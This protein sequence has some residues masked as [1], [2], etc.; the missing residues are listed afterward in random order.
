MSR[1]PAPD[2]EAILVSSP[3]KESQ[4]CE[5]AMPKEDKN[6]DGEM[7]TDMKITEKNSRRL[8]KKREKIR[9]LQTGPEG[10]SWKE[11]LEN[12]NFIGISE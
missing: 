12:W 7:N 10:T 8:S 1:A 6:H 11:Y 4:Q 3:M 2:K 5:A 9:K